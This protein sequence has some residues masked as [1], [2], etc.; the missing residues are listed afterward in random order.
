MSAQD[1]GPL[2]NVELERLAESVL[3]RVD[4]APARAEVGA[5]VSLTVEVQHPSG[6]RVLLD[7]DPYGLDQGWLVF[8]PGRTVSVPL[9]GGGL[10]TRIGYELAALEGGLVET[11]QGWIEVAARSVPTPPLWLVRG[12]ERIELSLDQP[13]LEVLGPL[14]EGELEP[15]PMPGLIEVPPAPGSRLDPLGLALLAAGALLLGLALWIA[16]RRR[17]PGRVDRGPTLEERLEALRAALAA[18]RLERAAV[19]DAA[20]LVR[21]AFDR[22][23]GRSSAGETDEHWLESLPRDGEWT[24]ARARLAEFLGR[25]TRV[26]F[27]ALEPTEWAIEE[28]MREGVEL[29]DA[30]D[31]LAP[32]AAVAGG[33]R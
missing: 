6:T 8:Q 7:G 23:L 30:A 3:T 27:A 2:A 14:E 20:R 9:D 17:A 26:R 25:A 10:V 16:R 1:T 32:P 5:P 19:F 21:D 28:L 24:A 31:R 18:G 4:L 22:R 15:R 11:E 13:T 29:V 12:E 33:E